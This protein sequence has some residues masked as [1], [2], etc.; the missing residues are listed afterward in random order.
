MHADVHDLPRPLV[1]GL[2][3]MIWR[4][5]AALTG[6]GDVGRAQ[7]ARWGDGAERLHL[8]FL[9]RPE[10]R[11][12]TRGSFLPTGTTSSRLGREIT[13]PPV[14]IGAGTP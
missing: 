5:E 4:M 6:L 3:T 8:W 7:P 10:G 2:G 1:D 11:A 13:G 14:W 9:V 12:Q